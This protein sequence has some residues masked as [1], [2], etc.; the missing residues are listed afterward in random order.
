V[1][2]IV[3]ALSLCAATLFTAPVWAEDEGAPIED[4][5]LRYPPSSVRAGLIIGGL[6]LTAAA[7][8]ITALAAVNWDDVPGADAMLIPVV[9][10]WVAFVQNDCAPDDPDCGA[11]LVFRGIMLTIDALV[12]AGG[13]AIAGEGLF[14][15]T[16]ADAGPAPDSV[17]WTIAPQVGPEHAGFGVIGTF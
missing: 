2:R 14:M 5:L 6:S 3:A 17:S 8:G 7:W 11:I 1:T 16:E 10:P 9:G 4:N 15:T 13:V 12:Q